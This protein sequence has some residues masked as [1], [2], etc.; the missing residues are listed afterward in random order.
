MR[1]YEICLIKRDQLYKDRRIGLQFDVDCTSDLHA[2]VLA[3]SIMSRQYC[4]LEIWYGD[5]LIYQRPER[6]H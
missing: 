5:Q 6:L 3:H 2:K 4:E 1:V